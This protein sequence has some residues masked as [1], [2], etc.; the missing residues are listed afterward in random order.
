[1]RTV[2]TRGR[3]LLLI[4][5][6]DTG[7]APAIGLRLERLFALGVDDFEVRFPVGAIARCF[8]ASS[9]GAA[10]ITEG[11]GELLEELRSG[12]PP[13]LPGSADEAHP[14]DAA[15]APSVGTGIAERLARIIGAFP[16]GTM[17]GMFKHTAHDQ[18]AGVVATHAHPYPGA[19]RGAVSAPPRHLMRV[20]KVCLSERERETGPTITAVLQRGPL[21]GRRIDVDVVEGRPPKTIDVPADDGSR[22]RYCLADWAQT[23]PSAIYTFLY[24][25]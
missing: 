17:R 15:D 12:L 21:A 25:V 8:A 16:C 4:A 3:A 10:A 2:L 9:N 7:I 11:A 14:I 18:I 23:G 13:N 22:C 1:M 6:L 19:G 5:Q 20:G 24:L